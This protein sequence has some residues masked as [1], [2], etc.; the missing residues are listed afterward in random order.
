MI[1]A[2]IGAGAMGEAI[3]A[4]MLHGGWSVGDVRASNA[5]REHRDRIAQKYGVMVGD[6]ARVVRDADAV[7]VAVK[8]HAVA[9]LLREIG[10][11]L[12]PTAVVVSVAAGLSLE[13][14][15]SSLPAEQPVVR[16]MPNIASTVGEGMTALSGGASAGADQMAVAA[17]IMGAVGLVVEVREN[18][19][20]A[21]TA[22][23]GS[24]PA[25]LMYV[26][27]A[28]TDAGVLLGLPRQ[29]ATKLVAQ[30]LYGSSKLLVTSGEHPTV[31]KDSVTSP[32][33]TTIAALRVFEDRGVKA[34]IIAGAEACRDRS[35][36]MGQAS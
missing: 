29:L 12:K 25:Y 16:A 36:E 24:G 20:N 15:Q 6:P 1:V 21:V 34:G 31:L 33:G 23:S 11:V 22:L 30:T 28:M 4:G 3:L 7:V 17:E 9:D 13:T 26:A 18:Q 35:V 32:G 27:E 19:M 10:P 2:I 14:L 5:T 8:P